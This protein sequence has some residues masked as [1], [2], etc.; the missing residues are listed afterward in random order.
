VKIRVTLSENYLQYVW[1]AEIGRGQGKDVVMTAQARRTEA[2]AADTDLR[3]A[4]QSELIYEQADPVLD[5]KLFEDELLVLDPRALALYSRRD[6]RWELKRLFSFESGIPLP[7]DP[8]GRLIDDGDSLRVFLPGMA[9]SGRRDPV[10]S[11]EC[12]QGY[13]TWDLDLGGVP[14][15]PGMNYFV[16]ENLP[17]FFSAA[18]VKDDTAALWIVTG[19]D[20]RAYLFD[21]GH[22]QVATL[23]GLGT[24]VAAVDSRCG[25]GRQLLIALKTDPGGHGAI[26]AFEIQRLKAMAVS[27]SVE[28]PGPVTALWSVQ[29]QSA[30]IAV[31]HDQ[32]TGRY[33]AF[34]LSLSCGR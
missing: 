26:Q 33:A 1:V 6:D 13:S 15:A 32:K 18:A 3:M 9:C 16:K 22:V 24:D 14:L 5:I 21:K 29:D 28:F 11:L 30:A 17:P 2:P 19:I 7:R 8:R 34:H 23:E 4:I 20:G 25:T 12:T 31:S 27:S 10:F